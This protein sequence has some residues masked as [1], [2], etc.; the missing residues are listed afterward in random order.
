MHNPRV[1]ISS[2]TLSCSSFPDYVDIFLSSRVCLYFDMCEKSKNCYVFDANI[3]LLFVYC[4]TVRKLRTLK[5]KKNKLSVFCFIR[6]AIDKY[7]KRLIF[8]LL[9]ETCRNS[10]AMILSLSM[11]SDICQHVFFF[12]Y[13]ETTALTKSA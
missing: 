3:V 6:E 5:K 9:R 1:C 10:N 4:K 2:K 13:F 12:F 7:P 11:P 8:V